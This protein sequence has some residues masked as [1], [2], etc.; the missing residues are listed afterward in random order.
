MTE[1]GQATVELVAALPALLLAGLVA[2]QLLAAGYAMTLADDATPLTDVARSS[3]AERMLL[4]IGPEGGWNAFEL[5]VLQA[6]GFQPA[7]MGPRTLRTDTACIAL[8]ALAPIRTLAAEPQNR[9]VRDAEFAQNRGSILAAG[10][11]VVAC[12]V[13]AHHRTPTLVVV[14]RMELVDQWR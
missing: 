3:P 12:A 1:R 7:G 2:L 6:H 11:T 4:A 9:R 10:K 8:L 14:D 13:I 5:E